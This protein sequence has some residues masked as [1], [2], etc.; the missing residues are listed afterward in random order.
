MSNTSGTVVTGGTGGTGTTGGTGGGG[1]APAPGG[2]VAAG[3]AVPPV[4]P[5]HGRIQ[6]VA[7]C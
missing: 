4:A 1:A 6:T 5:L 2:G 7:R 3:P